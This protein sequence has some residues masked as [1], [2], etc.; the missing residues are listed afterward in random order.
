MQ[1]RPPLHCMPQL[2]QL[3]SLVWASTQA[4]RQASPVAH[5]HAPAVQVWSVPQALLQAPQCSWFVCP[6]THSVPQ[7][8]PPFGQVQSPDVQL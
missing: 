8:R 6:S 3:S 2:P 7:S 1:E 4:L 5:V